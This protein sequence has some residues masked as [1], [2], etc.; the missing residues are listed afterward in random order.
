MLLHILITCNWNVTIMGPITGDILESLLAAV[1]EVE[2]AAIVSAEGFHIS[3]ALP[4]GVDETKFS[5]ITAALLSISKATIL[6]MRKMEFEELYVKGS[7]GCLLILQIG[8]KAVLAVSTT[9]DIK[10]GLI[11]KIKQILRDFNK[12]GADYG[13][14]SSFPV[15]PPDPPTRLGRS[16]LK[17]QLVLKE[18]ESEYELYCKNCGSKLV[19][20]QKVCRLCGKKVQ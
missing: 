15:I 13:A 20:E 19:K 6:E 8:S 7:D 4:Q 17:K 3:S 9:V 10:L 2:Y 14:V 16:K 1:P 18:K 11:S 5:A 12:F